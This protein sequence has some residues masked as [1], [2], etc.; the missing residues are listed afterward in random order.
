MDLHQDGEQGSPYIRDVGIVPPSP[1]LNH[2]VDFEPV[3]DFSSPPFVDST[4]SYNNS[5]FSGHS[6][7]SFVTA[8]NDLSFDIFNDD[9]TNPGLFDNINSAGISTSNDFDYDPAEY[10]PPHSGSLLMFND[11]GYMSP[12]YQAMPNSAS[13]D[14]HNSHHRQGSVPYDHSS[15]SSNGDP[16]DRRSRGSSVS[17]AYQGQQQPST[18]GHSPRLDVAHSFENMTVRSP[19]WGTEALPHQQ[20][21]PS[22]PRLMM[23]DNYGMETQEAP[24]INAPDGDGVMGGPQLHIVPATPIGPGVTGA[25]FQNS[26]EPLAQRTELGQPQPQWM[27]AGGQRQSGPSEP[28]TSRQASPFR[29]PAQPN[30]SSSQN[31]IFSGNSNSNPQGNFLYPQQSRGRSKSDNALEPPSWDHAFIQQQQLQQSNSALALD[32]EVGSRGVDDGG[33]GTGSSSTSVNAD[34]NTSG[35]FQMQNTF[36][37]SSAGGLGGE[38]NGFL[39][40]DTQGQFNMRRTKSESGRMGH[41]QSRSEDIRGMQQQPNMQHPPQHQQQQSFMGHSSN[42]NFHHGH[43][44]SLSASQGQQLMFNPNDFTNNSGMQDPNLLS[45]N[46]LPL[47]PIRSLSPGRGHIRRASSG[48]RSERGVGSD[49]WL[50]GYNGGSARASPY[51]SPNASPRVH[52]SELELDLERESQLEIPSGHPSAGFENEVALSG[53]M[54]MSS[55]GTGE[56]KA[57]DVNDFLGAASTLTTMT[58]GGAADKPPPVTALSKPNVTTL[59]TATASHRRRKNEAGFVCPFPGCGS[60][61]TRSFNLK[62]HIRSHREEKPFVCHWPGCGKGF[63][64]QHDCKRHEQLH[65]NYRPFTC[66]GCNRQFARMDAL[67]RHLRSEGGAECA[68]TQSTMDSK[69]STPAAQSPPPKSETQSPPQRARLPARDDGAYVPPG[70]QWGM[71]GGTAIGVSL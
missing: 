16:A 18:F 64:R 38:R 35:S 12:P 4:G 11:N 47:P 13:P 42:S 71:T 27:N 32:L 5:P 36:G 67:N 28:S 70:G 46:N 51:P 59:R 48:S 19:N 55:T 39:S 60:T 15:P 62:G 30:A 26:L 69:G 45:T 54:G 53:R 17:S 7:L 2:P 1:D 49:Q 58:V 43:S 37:G 44:L 14:H 56:T 24:T 63:A 29:F 33:L 3:L 57:L 65:T 61:F 23:S 9:R 8:E 52:Y 66:D 22:P 50:T 10:D 34:P 40:P 25:P 31:N 6:E 21:P 41:R 20:K 68:K